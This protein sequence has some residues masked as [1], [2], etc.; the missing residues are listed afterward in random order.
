MSNPHPLHGARLKVVRAEEH[1]KSFNEIGRR[2]IDTEPYEVVLKRDGDY[3]TVEGIVTAEPP[4]A[5]A[6]VVGEFVTNLRAALD[7]IAWELAMKAVRK[8]G[9]TLTGGQQRRIAF[10]ITDNP[11]TNKTG[12]A[13]PD[14]TPAHLANVCGV[15]AAAIG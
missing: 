10:P 9:I 13:K 7:Y 11:S 1:L 15:P 14:G 2:Y 6:C 5:L 3:I 12:F 8:A 4:P